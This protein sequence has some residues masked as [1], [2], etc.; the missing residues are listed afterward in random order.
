MESILSFVLQAAL[1]IHIL[2]LGVSIWR[3]WRGENVIDRLIASDLATTLALG[4]LVIGALI[5]GSSLYL[6][7]ALALALMGFVGT[8]ALTRYI[9]DQSMF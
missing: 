9:V 2:L 7:V 6:D 5:R 8:L 3:V 1:V 4:V